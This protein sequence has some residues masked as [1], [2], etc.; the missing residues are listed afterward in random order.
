MSVRFLVCP[1]DANFNEGSSPSWLSCYGSPTNRD[2]NNP[3]WLYPTRE[4]LAEYLE[5]EIPTSTDITDLLFTP[6][7]TTEDHVILFV[8]VSLY[9]A[10][11][12]GFNTLGKAINPR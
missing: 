9:F 7:L 5:V 8:A 6:I 11:C 3:R 4:E 12:W 1:E 10:T 2:G